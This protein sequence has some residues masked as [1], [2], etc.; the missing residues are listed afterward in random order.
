MSY[1]FYTLFFFLSAH[2]KSPLKSHHKKSDHKKSDH[3]K[4]D[5]KKSDH[6]K[7]DKKSDKEKK[8]KKKKKKKGGSA[9]SGEGPLP[10]FAS[11]FD[12]IHQKMEN[13]LSEMEEELRKKIYNFDVS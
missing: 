13:R 1:G 5:H 10:D 4:S 9:E 8:S 12:L 11:S 3:K 2:Q 7:S 6:K